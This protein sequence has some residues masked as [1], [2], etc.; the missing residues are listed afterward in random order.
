MIFCAIVSHLLGRKKYI[1]C[2]PA[3]WVFW[4]FMPCFLK[5]NKIT[6]PIHKQHYSLICQEKLNLTI[7]PTLHPDFLLILA[8]ESDNSWLPWNGADDQCPHMDAYIQILHKQMYTHNAIKY[9]LKAWWMYQNTGIQA[10]WTCL[11]M[12][13]RDWNLPWWFDTTEA[14]WNLKSGWKI[15]TP[16]LE[17]VV[18][19]VRFLYKKAHQVRPMLGQCRPDSVTIQLYFLWIY[20]NCS[21][22]N[23]CF[24]ADEWHQTFLHNII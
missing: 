24:F 4:L 23:S 19:P 11:H 12:L 10:Y 9:I 3:A 2:T 20:L 14:V 15:P 17:E 8:Q 1:Q 5:G 22:L 21:Y 13:T 7:Q 16:G 6:K 18:M